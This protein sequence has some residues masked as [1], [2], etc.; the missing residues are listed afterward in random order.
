MV[1]EE[2]LSS[3][4]KTRALIKKEKDPFKAKVLDGRQLS[5]KLTANS[6]YGQLGAK[7]SS[8]YFKEMAACTTAVGRYRI[9]D[10]VSGAKNWGKLR[11]GGK[12][13][14]TDANIIYGDTD[15][16]F[17]KFDMN[18][19]DENNKPTGERYKGLEAREKS[20]EY[21]KE[22][23][24][25]MG[26]NT[27]KG[28]GQ[29]LE[30]EKEF[31]PMILISKKRYVGNK[32]E[33]NMNACYRDSNGI[34]TKRRDNAPIVKYVFGNVIEKIIT[35]KDIKGA[36]EFLE[37]T[38]KTLKDF[39]LE[40]FIISKTLRGYY[41]CPPAHKLLADRMAERDPG[42]KPRSNDRIPYVFIKIPNNKLFKTK[43]KKNGETIQ[44]K[45]HVLQG[46]RI[47]HADYFR[48]NKEKKKLEI[49]Y[50]LYITN[51]IMNP[52]IQVLDLPVHGS[53][54]PYTG[55]TATEIFN[56]AIQYYDTDN[57]NQ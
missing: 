25:Y 8:I 43:K 16:I 57:E 34:V 56:D 32:Y 22:L 21:G 46:D 50:K 12:R 9:N 7:T 10:A 26:A 48:D 4:A 44:I 41:K 45:L 29:C 42:N 38:L 5:Y 39:P 37:K 23:Q 6:I 28:T 11:K 13:E 47:E 15:S 27:L 51:Q 31:D 33:F 55:K 40:D 24:E 2:L 30:Y 54:E 49:D 20:K 14:F 3:R 17:V 53:S 35:D 19:Y 36:H 1:L 52:V 18:K